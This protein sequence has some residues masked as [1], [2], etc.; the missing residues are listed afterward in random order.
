MEV[1]M[2]KAD[3]GLTTSANPTPTRRSILSGGVR[4]AGAAIAGMT[5][6][7]SLQ[8]LAAIP[9]QSLPV[10]ENA[11]KTLA[12]TRRLIAAMIGI[13]ERIGEADRAH[14]QLR[15]KKLEGKLRRVARKL[16]KLQK[17]LPPPQCWLDIVIR[18][19][20]AGYMLVWDKPRTHWQALLDKAENNP[21][22]G[23]PGMEELAVAVLYLAARRASEQPDVRAA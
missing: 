5:A 22:T 4:I 16:D 19:E 23:N 1:T 18:A 20:I 7:P 15:Q 8:A 6:I 12:E 2:S 13:E 17:A 11:Q 21:S 14:D 3:N 10:N 9:G